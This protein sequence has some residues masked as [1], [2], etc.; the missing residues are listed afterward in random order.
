VE[1]ANAADSNTAFANPADLLVGRGVSGGF[2]GVIDE[3]AIYDKALSPERIKR[4][5][6]VGSTL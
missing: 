6:T 4:H 1:V 5:H 3:V 2:S